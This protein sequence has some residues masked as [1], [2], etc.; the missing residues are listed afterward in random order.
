[1]LTTL[2]GKRDGRD[3]SHRTIGVEQE[4]GVPKQSSSSVRGR[5]LAVL[6]AD[7]GGKR[8]SSE[9]RTERW[10]S[11]WRFWQE[12]LGTWV[13]ELRLATGRGP[14]GKTGCPCPMRTLRPQPT[15]ARLENQLLNEFRWMYAG[16]P[17][18]LRRTQRP[19]CAGRTTVSLC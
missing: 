1:M 7:D 18:D 15:D 5:I 14:R 8:G 6:P 12:N 16:A 17:E 10:T 11:T 9:G 19:Q 2:L 3:A 4:K 13:Q